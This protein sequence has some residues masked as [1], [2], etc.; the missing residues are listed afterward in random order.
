MIS[1]ELRGL[2]SRK[3][4]VLDTKAVVEHGGGV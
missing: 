2:L 4:V 3:V 1:D